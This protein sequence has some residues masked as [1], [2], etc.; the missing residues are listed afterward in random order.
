MSV[1]RAK[2]QVAKQAGTAEDDGLQVGIAARVRSLL[3]HQFAVEQRSEHHIFS[4][5]I[6]TAAACSEDDSLHDFLRER[7]VATSVCVLTQGNRPRK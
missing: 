3:G 5:L 7:R 2:I 1:K 6:D 4:E